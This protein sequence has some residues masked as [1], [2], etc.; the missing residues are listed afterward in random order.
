MEIILKEVEINKISLNPEEVL[1]VKCKGLDLSESFIKDFGEHLKQSFPNNR[2]H[3]LL[4][5]ENSDIIFEKVSK[6]ELT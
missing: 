4:L 3:M 5:E 6:G 1:I 2:I